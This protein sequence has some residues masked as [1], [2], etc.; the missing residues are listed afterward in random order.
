[1]SAD[2]ISK[3]YL[4]TWLRRTAKALAGSGRLSE[5]SM[6]LAKDGDMDAAAW[7]SKIHRILEREEEPCFEILTKVDS[8][9][10]RPAKVIGNEGEARDLFN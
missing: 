3:P 1:M 5:V 10:A 8:V 6:I 7:R 9:L 4:N 2:G